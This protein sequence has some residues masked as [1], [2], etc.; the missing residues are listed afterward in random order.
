MLQSKTNVPLQLFS[1]SS[2]GEQNNGKR[3]FSTRRERKKR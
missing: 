1:S 3:D 2:G